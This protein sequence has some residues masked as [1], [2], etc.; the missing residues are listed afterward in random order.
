VTKGAADQIVVMVNDMASR[1]LPL[2]VSISD[3]K[4]HTIDVGKIR[5]LDTGGGT[6]MSPKDLTPSLNGFVDV[7]VTDAHG[8]TVLR[9]TLAARTA[10]ASPSP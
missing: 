3:T 1:P 7:T 4:G 10:V 5:T 2:S 6:V 9:G 8:H